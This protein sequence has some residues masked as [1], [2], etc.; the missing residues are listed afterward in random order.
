MIE[1]RRLKNDVIFIQTILKNSVIYKFGDDNT[2][3]VASK[4]RDTLLETLENESESA[5]NWFRNNNMILNPV[6]SN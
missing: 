5:V 4:T 6:N 3:S 2:I 1:A